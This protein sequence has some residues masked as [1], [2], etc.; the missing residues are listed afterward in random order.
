MTTRTARVRAGGVLLATDVHLPPP[1]PTGRRYPAV[2]IRTPYGRRAHRPEAR[3]WTARGFAAV[4]QDVRGRYGSG[5]DWWPYVHERADGA[6]TLRWIRDRPWSDGR[7][8]AAG[9][10]YAAY[11]ALVTATGRDREGTGA[12]T[13]PDAVVA[14]VPALGTAETAREPSGAERLLG[15][16]GWWAAHG[17]RT[18]SD[19]AAL[20]RLLGRDPALLTHLPVLDLPAR[21]GRALPSWP[22]IWQA[23]RADRVIRSAPA[24]RTPL[25]AIG[26]THDPFAAD[27]LALWRAWGGPA[28]LLL[29]PWGHRLIHDPGPG[30]RPEHRVDPGGLTA[31]WARAV[32]EGHPPEGRRGAVAL[33]GTPYWFPATALIEPSAARRFPLA[34][35]PL[36]VSLLY[37]ADFR[38]DPA[39]PVRSDDLRADPP[40]ADG[41]RAD[42]ALFV[43]AP[44]ARATDL[45]GPAAAELR[46]TAGTPVADW[47][48]RLVALD[49]RGRAEPLALGTARTVRTPGT[50][51]TVTVPLGQL[52]RRL[53]AGTRLRIE[54]AGHHFPAH[55]RN[56]HTGEDPVTAVRLLPSD[57]ALRPADCALLLP[58]AELRGSDAVPDLSQEI[59]T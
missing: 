6:A 7:V 29:G 59:R 26:G 4:V 23:R 2:L 27:T 40:R 18:D 13:E 42:R 35:G 57:R 28:R 20:D 50:W 10:S 5:G 48:V 49:P 31:A 12:G 51:S 46:A 30:A 52:A 32:C 34:A 21:L 24:A 33:A 22:G 14:A 9:S 58:V 19:P 8:V 17:D 45:L 38:A 39:R 41:D 16:A 54:A 53:P 15:R 47:F 1:G 43:T 56:P 25:L 55:A 11:C 37:G 3:A 36:G 44:L